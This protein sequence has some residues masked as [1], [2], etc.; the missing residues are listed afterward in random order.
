MTVVKWLLLIVAV[1]GI[2]G[3]GFGAG[4]MLSPHAEADKSSLASRVV[5][6]VMLGV[7]VTCV[8]ILTSL[9]AGS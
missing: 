6:W 2:G 3:G 7:G 8:M 1:V 5:P 4:A 9:R